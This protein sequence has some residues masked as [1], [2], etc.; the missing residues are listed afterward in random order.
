[1]GA[2][3]SHAVLRRF[4]KSAPILRDGLAAVLVA[5]DDDPVGN[6]PPTETSVTGKILTLLFQHANP[7]HQ[8]LPQCIASK[9]FKS[10]AAGA[11]FLLR[12]SNSTPN[13]MDAWVN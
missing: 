9:D 5:S 6:Q 11:L 12:S 13:D 4:T 7:F 1:M 8:A 10:G 2:H 3:G